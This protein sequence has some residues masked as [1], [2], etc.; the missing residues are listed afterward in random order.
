[1]H[2]LL[3]F[4]VSCRNAASYLL[5]PHL[6]QTALG[7]ISRATINIS[8]TVRTCI[9]VSF[10]GSGG[11]LD[12]LSPPLIE[13]AVILLLRSNRFLAPLVIKQSFRPP[14]ERFLNESLHVY[15]PYCVLC[16]PS[17]LCNSIDL[18]DYVTGIGNGAISPC[19]PCP[20]PVSQREYGCYHL[21]QCATDV[22]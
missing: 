12:L 4:I 11:A 8:Y 20:D 1:M 9:R 6:E 17:L 10:R 5:S 7:T 15:V 19:T 16:Y 14:L 22:F 3:W 18:L 21:R 2:T 13:V